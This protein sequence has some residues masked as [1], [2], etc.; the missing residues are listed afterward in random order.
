MSKRILTN[1]LISVIIF[2]I[3][4][5]ITPKEFERLTYQSVDKMKSERIGGELTYTAIYSKGE[6]Q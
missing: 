3:N 6:T 4:S 5:D 2:A 1:S